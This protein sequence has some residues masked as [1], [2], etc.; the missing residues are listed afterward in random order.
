MVGYHQKVTIIIL[1]TLQSFLKRSQMKM[2]DLF[3]VKRQKTVDAVHELDSWTELFRPAKIQGHP[4]PGPIRSMGL[5]RPT[6]ERMDI[7]Q[8]SITRHGT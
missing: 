2:K 8:L 3:I 5:L 4:V 6:S 1:Q 7:G